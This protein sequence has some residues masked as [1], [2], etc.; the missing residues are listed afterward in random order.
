MYKAVLFAGLL[1]LAGC[2]RQE[3]PASSNA[4]SDQQAAAAPQASVPAQRASGE[5]RIAPSEARMGTLFEVAFKLKDQ[6]GQVISDA[7]VQAVF[8][9]EMGNITMREPV[10]MNWNGS[11]YVGRYAP[12]MSGEWEVNVEAR[13]NGQLLL[14]MPSTIQVKK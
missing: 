14:S 10:A 9:M 4:R 6:S 8:V 3:G 2:A 7:N 12:T 1:T 5:V 11:E 13:K